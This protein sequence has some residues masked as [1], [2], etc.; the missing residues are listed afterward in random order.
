MTTSATPS[1]AVGLDDDRDADWLYEIG[2]DGDVSDAMRRIQPSAQVTAARTSTILWSRREGPEDLHQLLDALADFGLAPREIHESAGGSSRDQPSGSE[3]GEQSHARP[4]YCEVRLPCRLGVAALHHLGWSHRVE[5]TTVVRL[6][7]S[8]ASLRDALAQ[9]AVI[10]GVD[11]VLAI[12]K[13]RA[14]PG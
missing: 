3:L 7:A 6:R 9:M 12:R 14:A 1:P 8:Q 4:P 5:R 10:A 2:L 11:Y 13:L